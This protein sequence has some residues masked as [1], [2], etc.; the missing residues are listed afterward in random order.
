MHGPDDS[1]AVG[2]VGCECSKMHSIV[3]KV[4]SR[5]VLLRP[6]NTEYLMRPQELREDLFGYI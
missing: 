4:L 5:L 6:S 2:E 3:A 1:V